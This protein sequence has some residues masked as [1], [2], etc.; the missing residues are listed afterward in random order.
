MQAHLR[1]THCTAC[2]TC[3][4]GIEKWP[5]G[6]HVRPPIFLPPKIWKS[7]PLTRL[8][9]EGRTGVGHR[10]WAQ[11]RTPALS[12][13]TEQRPPSTPASAV[14]TFPSA[15]PPQLVL[16]PH[17]RPAERR[18]LRRNQGGAGGIISPACLSS[19][20]A[21]PAFHSRESGKQSGNSALSRESSSCIQ[22]K[23]ALTRGVR[24]ASARQAAV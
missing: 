2:E 19:L 6:R 21:F 14:P 15:R 12:P 23:K 7:F 13:Q 17:S 9:G 1:K 24:A 20:S 4:T 11:Q 5:S 22:A 8:S 3:T 16:H 18:S 10:R